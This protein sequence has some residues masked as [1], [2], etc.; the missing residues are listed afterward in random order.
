MNGMPVHR[1][2]SSV[3]VRGTLSTC[4]STGPYSRNS[5][6]SNSLATYAASPSRLAKSA[7]AALNAASTSLL[8]ISV[9]RSVWSMFA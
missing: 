4:F 1:W 9:Y 5:G 8:T 7:S 2:C 6:W 3:T